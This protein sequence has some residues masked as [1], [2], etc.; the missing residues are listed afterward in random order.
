MVNKIKAQLA[1]L[2]I[3]LALVVIL[4]LQHLGNFWGMHLYKTLTLTSYHQHA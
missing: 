1:Q 3:P 4:H 2:Y